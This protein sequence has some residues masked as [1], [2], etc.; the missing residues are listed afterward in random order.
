MR[1]K[2]PYDRDLLTAEVMRWQVLNVAMRPGVVLLAGDEGRGE[3]GRPVRLQ[4]PPSLKKTQGATET[5]PR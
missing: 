5:K 2:L 1:N 4:L 3:A